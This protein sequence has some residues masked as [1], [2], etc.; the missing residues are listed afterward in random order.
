M[1]AG[2]DPPQPPDVPASAPARPEAPGPLP[3]GARP[4][5]GRIELL[6]RVG[7]VLAVALALAPALASLTSLSSRYDWRYFESMAEVARRSV[8]WFGQAPLWNPYSCGG[9]VD[10]ANP[11]S[12]SA[13]PTF[14]FTLL[15]GTA[16]G[17]KLALFAYLL[18]ALDGTYRLARHL[19]IGRAGSAVAA[20]CYGLSGYQAMH[21]SVGHINFAGVSLYPYLVLFFDRS[22]RRWEWAIP[23]G[24]IAAWIAVLG[25]TFTPAVAAELLAMWA[26]WSVL[27]PLPAGSGEPTA[28]RL[29]GRLARVLLLLGAA[30]AVA[31]LVSA[32]RMLPALEFITDHPRP[33]FRRT[34]DT[35]TPLQIFFDLWNWRDFGGL[36][37]RKYWSHE[38]TA[39][40][41]L[42]L[43]PLLIGVVVLYRRLERTQK[44]LL[45]RLAGLALLGALLSMGNFASV[46]P[47]SL[48][49]R[50]PV[51]RD[52]RVPSRHLVLVTLWLA[53]AGGLGAQVLLGWLR[54]RLAGARGQK[55]V[56]ALCVVLFVGCAV[57][58]GAYFAVRMR[59][60]F[61]V[62][63]STPP[64]PVPFYHL[65]GH[66]Q[67]MRELIF[68]G[69]GVLGC[70]EE[71]PLQRAELIDEGDVPQARFADPA[72]G[73]VLTSHVTPNVR[74]I[75]I[76]LL[77]P[78]GLLLLNSNWNEHFV[79]SPPAVIHKA[80]GRLAVDLRA[81]PPG[82]HVV[83]VRYAP[84][85]FA[86]GRVLTLLAVPILAAVFV[87]TR[88]RRRAAAS[89]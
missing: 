7:F 27:A 63:L 46:A 3:R 60:G 84:R 76:D 14:L 41:P 86:I 6:I 22:L 34:P 50:L 42:L 39:R 31:L 59:G 75:T 38:Y 58:A 19:H 68:E 20:V 28:P 82:R 10:L 2:T 71:A 30:G 53:L 69:H 49:Q 36:R 57:D 67:V 83:T 13:A 81:L 1:T 29:P 55:L 18:M 11:Q 61:T 89:P 35:S 25:G 33:L 44:A 43:A 48:L 32:V 73:T 79:A 65:K 85:S 77:Q 45:H 15:L 37:G 52:L 8:V 9:E 17:F 4:A 40:L 16:V 64:G 72:A 66:W 87:L 80:A 24:A 56:Q 54:G 5:S 23:A 78:G 62:Q 21:L 51:L 74:E 26:A 70:D 12:M 47:W 88:R